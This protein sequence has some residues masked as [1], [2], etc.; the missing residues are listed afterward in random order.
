MTELSWRTT[1]AAL[2]TAIAV[3]AGGATAARDAQDRLEGDFVAL[4]LVVLDKQSRPVR[5][6]RVEDFVVRED[7]RPVE[8]KTFVAVGQDEDAV[9]G[10]RIVLLLDDSSVPSSGTSVIQAMARDILARKTVRDEVS[11]VRL[12][13]E[14]DEAYGD[15]ETA[16]SR[17]DGYHG[18]A[19][20]FQNLGTSE[21]VLR[22]VAAVARQLEEIEQRRKLIVCIGG[23]RVCNVLE[24]LHS[25]PSLWRSW[26]DAVATASRANVAIYAV[27]P[28]PIGT[29][30]LLARGLADVTG[31]DGFANGSSFDAFVDRIWTEAREYYLLGYWPAPNARDLHS[32]EVKLPHRNGVRV[33]VRRLRG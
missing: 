1:V 13:N 22:V 21:R 26:I 28:V 11:V 9:P 2:L 16:L 25:Y 30:M 17:I 4:D 12:N 6:L 3:T 27:M 7:G 32:I 15:L 8:L 20:P 31:G 33:Q 29:P 23:P 10:R 19:V 24:P 14:R 18:G 5:G